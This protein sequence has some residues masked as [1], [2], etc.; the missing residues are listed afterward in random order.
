MF[1]NLFS[2][3]SHLEVFQAAANHLLFKNTKFCHMT[4]YLVI[5]HTNKQTVDEKNKVYL[6]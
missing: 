4:I 2:P 5:K 6:I 3:M 1:P